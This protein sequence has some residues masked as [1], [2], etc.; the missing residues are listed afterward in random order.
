MYEWMPDIQ[1]GD[2][3]VLQS[4]FDILFAVSKP[5]TPDSSGTE[6]DG[7]QNRAGDVRS[8]VVS[9]ISFD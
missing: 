1:D 3:T 2:K 5:L 6:S 8:I 9:E 7:G 4:L